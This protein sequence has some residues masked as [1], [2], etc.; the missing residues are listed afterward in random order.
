[1]SL[2]LLDMLLLA[3]L[4]GVGVKDK[5]GRLPSAFLKNN[6]LKGKI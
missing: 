6:V 1:M 2:E 4:E 5:C 3:Y